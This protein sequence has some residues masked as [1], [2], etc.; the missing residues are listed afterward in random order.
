MKRV[1]ATMMLICIMCVAAFTLTSCSGK[2]SDGSLYYLLKEDDTYEVVEPKDATKTEMVIVETFNKK[3]ITS[4]SA[5]AFN[6]CNGVRFI[7]VIGNSLLKIDEF[8]FKDCSNLKLI[9]LPD[10]LTEIGPRAFWDCDVLRSV[11]VGTGLTTIGSEAFSGCRNLTAINYNGT[12][13]QW[14]AISKG[15]KWDNDTGNYVVHCTDGDIAKA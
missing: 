12:I 10:S 3:K 5:R 13:E 15:E 9:T 11:T 1:L 8:A 6:G 14:N 2:V 7:Y 4:I